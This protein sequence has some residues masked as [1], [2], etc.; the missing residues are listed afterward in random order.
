VQTGVTIMQMDAGLDTGGILL[1]KALTIGAEETAGELH[2]RLAALGAELIVAALRDLP[3]PIAQDDALATY[4]AKIAKDE[5]VID[6]HDNAAQIA[7]K[8]RA[9]NPFP[10]AVTCL[11]GERIKIWRARVAGHGAGEPGTVCTAM[12][13]A[14]LVA[15]GS[16]ALEIVTLQRA[17]GKRLSA[18]TF[19]AGHAIASG[20]RFGPGAA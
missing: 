13:D 4:A 11:D 7:L 20:A 1:K 16:G 15:C 5:A 19:L 2:D 8:V 18:E 10:G 3:A 14:L 9:Y 12:R 6:W 17:G